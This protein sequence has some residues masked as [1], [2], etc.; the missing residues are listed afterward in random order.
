MM[1]LMIITIICERRKKND[2]MR[3]KDIKMHMM[4]ILMLNGIQIK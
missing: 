4:E 3:M 2:F 1:I